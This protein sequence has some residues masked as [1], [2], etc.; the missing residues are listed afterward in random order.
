MTLAEAELFF[1]SAC[2]LLGTAFLCW[3]VP[4]LAFL[5]RGMRSRTASYL[6]FGPALVWFLWHIAH[7]GEADFGQYR[8]AFFVFFAAVGLVALC[9]LRDFLAVRG[10]CIL[11]LLGANELLKAAFLE[12]P[13]SRL[14]MVSGLYGLILLAVYWG[15]WPYRF[16]DFI[17]WFRQKE[18]LFY[19]RFLGALLGIHGCLVL[20]AL[21]G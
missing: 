20:R 5:R 1:G 12:E 9:H 14:W 17:D 2:L 10:A 4:W 19:P 18:G 6:C 21:Y 7:L 8:W 3:P 15:V 16:R 13:L 11:A